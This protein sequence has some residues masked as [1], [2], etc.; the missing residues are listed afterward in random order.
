MVMARTTEP[1]TREDRILA[2]VKAALASR[3]PERLTQAAQLLS[4]MADFE[5]AESE[6]LSRLPADEPATEPAT[7]PAPETPRA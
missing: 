3:R 6:L 2:A 7:E 1:A 5:R 4:K